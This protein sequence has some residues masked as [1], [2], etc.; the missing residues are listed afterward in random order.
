MNK[1][2]ALENYD[3]LPNQ[4]LEIHPNI[5]RRFEEKRCARIFESIK[6]HGYKLCYPIIVVP[7]QYIKNGN[8][9]KY[10]VCG[11]QHRFKANQM[12]GKSGILAYVDYSLKTEADQACFFILDADFKTAQKPGAYWD[13]RLKFGC[14]LAKF[15]YNL[16]DGPT[17]L[18]NKIQ[19]KGYENS[20]DRLTLPTVIGMISQIG[21]NHRSSKWT[22][23]VDNQLTKE[24]EN[25]D[26]K[27]IS[28]DLDLFIQFVIKCFGTQAEI[29][30][31][32]QRNNL[33]AVIDFYILAKSAGIVGPENSDR[34]RFKKL[35]KSFEKIFS[36][37]GI[38]KQ[39]YGSTIGTKEVPGKIHQ[40]IETLP[41]NLIGKIN[42]EM[43]KRNWG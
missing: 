24:I 29:P 23:D 39:W 27:E 5:Q 8:S 32:Y 31:I 42:Q 13:A 9:D 20:K 18:K 33:N 38:S 43:I 4:K 25:S 6:K 3:F 1:K 26:L 2:E 10:Y 21:L 7:G 19:I 35:K 14:P 17:Y 12:A 15:V 37:D 34:N 36:Y 30:K 41:K 40:L 11:G 28:R 16:N 22:I